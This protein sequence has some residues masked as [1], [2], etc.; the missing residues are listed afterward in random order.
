MTER[1][2]NT[3]GELQR[4]AQRV[5]VLNRIRP[6]AIATPLY[7]LLLPSHRRG[8]VLLEGVGRLYIDPS[9]HLGRTILTEGAYEPETVALLHQHIKPGDVV[10]D[11]GANEGVMSACAANLVGTTGCVV[12]IE[13]QRRLLDILEINLALNSTGTYHIVHGAVSDRDDECVTLSL[14]PEGNTG[15]SSIVSKYRWN[16]KK[17]QVKTYTIEHI[18]KSYRIDHIDFVKIDVEGYE[19]EVVQALQPLLKD[20]RIGKAL[21]DYH[22][23]ILQARGINAN[24]VHEDILRCGY[25]PLIGSPLGGY[26]LYSRHYPDIL[27][28]RVHSL[29]PR[30]ELPPKMP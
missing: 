2:T 5:K 11:I 19:P 21:V 17:E 18:T 4:W 7:K 25:T 1:Y 13:P 14:H 23:S 29:P 30:S 22:A 24:A 6:N 9:S 16:G 10:F 26:V 27:G 20:R 28:N 8:I 15:A 12:A 3:F